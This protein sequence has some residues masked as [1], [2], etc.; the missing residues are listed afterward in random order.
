MR[1]MVM[2]NVYKVYIVIVALSSKNV[3]LVYRGDDMKEK[4]TEV[5]T[6][7]TTPAIKQSLQQEAEERGWSISQLSER[8]IEEYVKRKEAQRKPADAPDAD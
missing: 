6:Y 1:N 2:F 5:I 3:Y 8:I 4:K 7:R